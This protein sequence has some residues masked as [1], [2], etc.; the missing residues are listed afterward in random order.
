VERYGI[1][2]HWTQTLDNSTEVIEL[3]VEADYLPGFYLSVLINSPRVEPPPGQNEDESE[4]HAGNVDLGKPTFRLGYVKI[5]VN[6]DYK[7]IDQA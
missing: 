2:H 5:D 3:P 6:D 7:A 4:Q 1:L